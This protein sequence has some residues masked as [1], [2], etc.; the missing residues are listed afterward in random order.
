M[1]AMNSHLPSEHAAHAG[2]R[3]EQPVERAVLFLLEQRAA[4]AGAREEQEHHADAGGVERDQSSF[5]PSL[6]HDVDRVESSRLGDAGAA[7]AAGRRRG[8]IRISQASNDARCCAASAGRRTSRTSH[9]RRAPS[10]SGAAVNADFLQQ[11]LHDLRRDRIG[12]IGQQLDARRGDAGAPEAA[13]AEALRQDDRHR[14]RAVPD[15]RSAPRRDRA[16]VARCRRR[17]RRVRTRSASPAAAPRRA[18]ARRRCRP[19]RRRRRGRG[20]AVAP[21]CRTPTAKIEK[22]TIGSRNVSACATRS[23]FRLSQPIRSSVAIIRAA[24]VP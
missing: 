15:Q 19:R 8:C 14:H 17:R 23:R 20:V 18:P 1:S 22:K 21:D 24:P 13:R 6:P 10:A 2:A 5:G 16:A 3:A 7:G 11:A 12:G 4:G 9:A